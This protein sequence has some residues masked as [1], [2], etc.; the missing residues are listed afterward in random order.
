MPE[1]S[2]ATHLLTSQVT[3]RP[4]FTNLPLLISTIVIVGQAVLLDGG[5]VEEKQGGGLKTPLEHNDT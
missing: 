3:K 1:L 2:L 5:A 4:R